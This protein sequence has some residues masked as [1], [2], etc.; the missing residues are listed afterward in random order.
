MATSKV[1]ICGIN[2]ATLRVLKNSEMTELFALAR[3]GDEEARQELINGN[4]KLVL[5]VIKSFAN[6]GEDINDLFQIGCIGLIKA[7]D[8]FDCSLELC[9]STYAVPMIAGELRRFLRDNSAIRISRSLRDLSYKIMQLKNINGELPPIDDISKQL[10][11]DRESV[12]L[13]LESMQ[14]TVSLS[15]PIYNDGTDSI[16]LEDHLSD[17]KNYEEEATNRI[18]LERALERLNQRERRILRMRFYRSKTQ[19]EIA[20]EL[21]ISQAQVS[22]LEKGALEKIRKQM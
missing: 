16:Y 4:L 8:N 7:V 3:N 6:R 21:G 22:R 9:F 19:M 17:E 5:S 20:D 18:A 10:G 14:D 15:E 12:I 2:T 1:E 11:T 13:A